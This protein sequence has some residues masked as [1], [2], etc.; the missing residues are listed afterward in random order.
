VAARNLLTY[1]L[2]E[3]NGPWRTLLV[4]GSRSIETGRE[5]MIYGSSNGALALKIFSNTSRAYLS[6]KYLKIGAMLDQRLLTYFGERNDPDFAWPLFTVHRTQEESS[7]VGFGMRRLL[8]YYPLDVLFSSTDARSH[9]VDTQQRLL[10]SAYL[11]H[12]LS[13]CHAKDVVVGDVKPD[14]MYLHSTGQH[15]A[16]IDCDSFQISLDGA[17]YTSDVGTREYASPRIIQ[18]CKENA[19]LSLEGV[20]RYPA[21]DVFGLG[22]ICFR[23][24]MHGYHPFHTGKSEATHR[25]IFENIEDRIFPYENRSIPA[26]RNAPISKYNNL[27]AEIRLLFEGTFQRGE[28][29]SSH[30]WRDVLYGY[31]KELEDRVRRNSEEKRKQR[32]GETK[33]HEVVTLAQVQKAA[34][35]DLAAAPLGFWARLSHRVFSWYTDL[36]KYLSESW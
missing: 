7:F 18:A 21:D 17:K 4:D 5:G 8:E 15:V 35:Q 27:P 12:L 24:L 26:P 2:K 23:L 11:F 3:P 20:L 25:S 13:L 31:A 33:G 16:L 32:G 34:S 22:I 19:W 10:I 28:H 9:E 6:G 14:N 29:I 1:F 36:R 30:Q